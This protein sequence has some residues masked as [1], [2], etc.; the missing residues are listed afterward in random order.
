[1]STSDTDRD[2]YVHLASATDHATEHMNAAAEHLDEIIT[3]TKQIQCM[4]ISATTLAAIP[5]NAG[6]DAELVTTAQEI[7]QTLRK[8][9][10]VEFNNDMWWM[11]PGELSTGILSEWQNG[12]TQVSFVWDWRE[13]RI[14]SFQLD[15]ECTSL[16]R[17]II[18]FQTML[19][20]NTDNNRTRRIK[21]V[22]IIQ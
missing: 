8:E 14:G 11:M 18:D 7:P 21:V 22:G 12:A 2:D 20:R 1:M 6:R 13:T 9:I 16:S 4:S 19:Q 10:L 15:G 3:A 5:S 17:Y